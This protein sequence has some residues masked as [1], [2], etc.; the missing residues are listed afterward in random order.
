VILE[1]LCRLLLPLSGLLATGL[2]ALAFIQKDEARFRV[3]FLFGLLA[4]ALLATRRW[5]CVSPAP[6]GTSVPPATTPSASA[7]QPTASRPR[8]LLLNASLAGHEGNSARLLALL[9]PR[10]APHAVLTHATLAGP[11]ATTFAALAPAL[12][13]A[14]AY[15]FATGTHWDSWS[16][17]LQK[18]LEDATPAEATRLWLGKP[19]AVLVTEHS[20][21]GKG[22]L[23]RLQG[24][25]VTLGCTL[26]PLSGLVLSHAAQLARL[27]A[28]A[29]PAADDLWRPAD[30]DIV[31]HNLLAAAQSARPTY[32]SWPVDRTAF[33]QPWLS[34]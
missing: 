4:L 33:A 23:S 31:A 25:L 11:Q 15:V 12:N 34:P 7:T 10:L 6:V 16:S 28:P 19:V 29:G 2:G 30:L 14:D 8:I 32:R 21:G 18:F 27:H 13:A 9:A 22:V 20:S 26:P 1:R 3:A 5:W 24:V 17:P